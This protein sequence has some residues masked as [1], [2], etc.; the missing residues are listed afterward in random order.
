[1]GAGPTREMPDVFNGWEQDLLDIDPS[2][3]PDICLDAREMKTLPAETYDAIWCS[4]TLEHFYRHEVQGILEGF[5]HVLKKDGFIEIVVP[6]M[7]ALFFSITQGNLDIEDVWYR[8]PSGPI[9]F[10]DVIYGFSKEMERGN[11][12]YAHKCGFSTESLCNA[13]LRAGF[14]SIQ[15]LDQSVNLAVRAYREELPCQ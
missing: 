5:M 13:I 14:K 12:F 9:M 7:Q 1:V 11:L 4:H 6:N 2:V 8:S 15:I 3:Q 10:H